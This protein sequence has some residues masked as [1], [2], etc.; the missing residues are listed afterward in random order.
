[1]EKEFDRIRQIVKRELADFQ[2]IGIED[3]E[4]DT[5]FS[6]DLHMNP[7]EM[8]DFIEI[9][10][11]AGLEVSDL[12]LTEVETFGDLVELINDKHI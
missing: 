9:L 4:D 10:G 2:G 7:T 6:E 11:K 12:D 1:M 8:T 5:F 3:I